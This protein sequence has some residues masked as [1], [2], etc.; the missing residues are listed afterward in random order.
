MIRNR[1]CEVGRAAGA[2]LAEMTAQATADAGMCASCAFRPGSVPN[3]CVT[4]VADA[5][6]CL[7]EGKTFWCHYGKRDDGRPA[8]ICAG[9][10]AS[11]IAMLAEGGVFFETSWPYSDDLKG[12]QEFE[13]RAEESI[14]EEAKTAL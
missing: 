5:M 1:P 8:H 2:H 13:R 6:K 4:T 9:W 12:M 7:F 14:G 3:G 11:T 10:K